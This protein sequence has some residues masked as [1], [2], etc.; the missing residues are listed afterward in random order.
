MKQRRLL[1]VIIAGA[2]INTAIT[3]L[4]IAPFMTLMPKMTFMENTRG[5]RRVL[6][7]FACWDAVVAIVNLIMVKVYPE[8]YMFG[9]FVTDVI[10]GITVLLIAQSN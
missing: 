6:Y 5:L 9:G 1:V 8:D 4:Q 2:V 10:S 3:T 7:G